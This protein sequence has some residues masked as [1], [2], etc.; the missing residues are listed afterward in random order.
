MKLLKTGDMQI[1]IFVLK[2]E[3]IISSGADRDIWKNWERFDAY[4]GHD[5]GTGDLP[6][7]P[8]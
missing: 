3:T 4:V 6:G 8:P 1:G 2:S 7:F 5:L